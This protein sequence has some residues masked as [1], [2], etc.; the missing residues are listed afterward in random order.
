MKR[1]TLLH[2]ACAS[3]LAFACVAQAQEKRPPIEAFGSD[4][5][6]RG[7]TR[8][9]YWDNAKNKGAGQLAIDYGRPVWK[10]A[11][12]DAAKFDAMTKGK[13][14]RMG[15]NYWTALDTDMPLTIS[16]KTV[17]VGIWYLGFHRST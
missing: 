9:G 4:S 8:V 15:S 2:L 17:P 3:I 7:T 10:A 14:W 12:E 6:E 11:Y 5:P 16:G 13:T 1:F